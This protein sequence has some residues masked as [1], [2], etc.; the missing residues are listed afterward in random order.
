MT[1]MMA[2]AI[3]RKLKGEEQ[4]ERKKDMPR[5]EAMLHKK[6]IL[7]MMKRDT[8]HLI[9]MIKSIMTEMKTRKKF[10]VETN[11]FQQVNNNNLMIQLFLKLMKRQKKLKVCLWLNRSRKRSE[12][13]WL[14][15]HSKSQLGQNVFQRTFGSHECLTKTNISTE[16]KIMKHDYNK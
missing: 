7:I 13:Q 2:L 9:K 12:R 14:N 5:L 1:K 4:E 16:S 10:H 11:K 6:K 8:V 15:W 3:F